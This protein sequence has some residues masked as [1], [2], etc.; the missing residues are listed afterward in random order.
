MA[1]KDLIATP[2][3]AAAAQIITRFRFSGDA[4]AELYEAVKVAVDDAYK[5]GQ[6]Q[7]SRYACNPPVLR[8]LN[9]IGDDDEH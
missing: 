8:H 2:G 3:E 6:T 9:F 1:L 7:G 5:L 4:K